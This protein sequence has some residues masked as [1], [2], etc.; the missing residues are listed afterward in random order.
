MALRLLE[1]T[2]PAEREED[3]RETVKERVPNAT[4]QCRVEDG[5][6]RMRLVIDA[7]KSGPLIDAVDSR[8]HIEVGYQLLMLPVEAVLPFPKDHDVPEPELGA[9]HERRPSVPDRISRVELFH[10]IQDM[11]KLGRVFILTTI[12]SAIV[13]IVGILRDSVAIII[14]AMV[15]APLLGPNVALAF[16]AVLGDLP[17]L[18]SAL[19]CNVIGLAITLALSIALGMVIDRSTL[20]TDPDPRK[21]GNETHGEFLSRTTPE[22][23]YDVILALASG[24]AGALAITSGVSASLVGV[25]VAVALM[26]P[27]VVL[28]LSLGAGIP[29]AAGGAALLLFTNVICINLSGVATFWWQGIRPRTW[30]DAARARKSRKIAATVWIIALVAL[31]IMIA[32]RRGLS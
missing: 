10:D 7:S 11:T 15:I 2:I 8:F 5:V 21:P 31:S 20:P 30:W 24:S 12:L 19:Y 25:M 17:M 26:P 28:G 13:A 22:A 29:W 32:L 23:R 14:G 4:K 1:V 6:F 3:L 18:K 16:G 9:S 27:C